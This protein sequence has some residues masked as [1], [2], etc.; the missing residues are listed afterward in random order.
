MINWWHSFDF[1][2]DSTYWGPNI[3]CI[4]YFLEKEGFEVT[5]IKFS[6]MRVVFHAERR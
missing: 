6:G 5:K 2:D 4:K 1:P 3:L